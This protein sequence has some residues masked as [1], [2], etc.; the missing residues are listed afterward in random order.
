MTLIVYGKNK[1]IFESNQLSVPRAIIELYEYCGGRMGKELF[2][3]IIEGLINTGTPADMV[4]V[5]DHMSC[6]SPI[7]KIYTNANSFFEVED[8]DGK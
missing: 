6:E 8:E 5:F 2:A 7:V 3:K 4:D 1:E